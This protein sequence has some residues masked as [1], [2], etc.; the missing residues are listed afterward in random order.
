MQSLHHKIPIYRHVIQVFVGK[1]V[2]RNIT[3]SQIMIIV[4]AFS[5]LNFIAIRIRSFFNEMFFWFKSNSCLRNDKACTS[6]KIRTSKANGDI[7]QANIKQRKR[8][9]TRLENHTLKYTKRVTWLIF[10]FCWFNS[11]V[12][13]LCDYLTSARVALLDQTRLCNSLAW[14]I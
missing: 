2:T 1:T 14:S 12:T 6:T 3:T 7:K 13:G 10:S 11:F 9:C 8:Q 5:L 4:L